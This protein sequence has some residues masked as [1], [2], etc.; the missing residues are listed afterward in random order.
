MRFFGYEFLSFAKS[1]GKNIGK[2][3]SKNLNVNIARNFLI[4]LNSLPQMRLKLLQ[5]QHLKKQRRKLVI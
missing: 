1:V 3:I 2:N 4:M 5:K